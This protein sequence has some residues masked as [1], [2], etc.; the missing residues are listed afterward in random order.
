MIHGNFEVKKFKGHILGTMQISGVGDKV[1]DLV[2]A[3]VKAEIKSTECVC[4][5]FINNITHKSH[6]T[7]EMA[8]LLRKAIRETPLT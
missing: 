4:V 2:R 5:H 3:V 6:F 7:D 8:N 1:V